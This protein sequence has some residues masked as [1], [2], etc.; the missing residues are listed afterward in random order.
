M[1]M[2]MISGCGSQLFSS[3]I[4]VVYCPKTSQNEIICRLCLPFP[5]KLL[6]MEYYYKEANDV[7]LKSWVDKTIPALKSHLEKA[8]ALSAKTVSLR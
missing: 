6:E 7:D 1:T 3:V 8:E 5:E 2:M 4:S